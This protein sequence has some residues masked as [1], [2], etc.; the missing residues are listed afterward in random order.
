MK[1]SLSQMAF[2]ES[3]L[4]TEE[5]LIVKQLVEKLDKTLKVEMKGISPTAEAL[6]KKANDIMLVQKERSA[7]VQMAERA[8]Q[9]MVGRATAGGLFGGGVG[10]YRTRGVAG[11]AEGAA[12]G[13][14][15]G[16]GSTIPP[17]LTT[18][19]LEQT[20]SHPEAAQLYKKAIGF[21]VQ[22]SEGEAVNLA[23][24]AMAMA[25][26]RETIKAAK[27]SPEFAVGQ[28]EAANAP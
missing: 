17:K 4:N 20:L 6:Y 23:R 26:I 14:L 11:A 19:I 28:Q 21:F 22:G 15:A 1:G 24:R 10:M 3:G 12:L 27:Q 25:G 7:A 2:K 13:A 5:R 8:M 16:A 18:L 9:T